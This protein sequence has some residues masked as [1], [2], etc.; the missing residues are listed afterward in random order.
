M[1]EDVSEEERYS[2]GESRSQPAAASSSSRENNVREHVE[3]EREVP[4]E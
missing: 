3:W 4:L 1:S 2:S